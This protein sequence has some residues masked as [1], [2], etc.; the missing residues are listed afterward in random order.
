M[1]ATTSTAKTCHGQTWEKSSKE[2]VIEHKESL[3]K[4]ATEY[5]LTC[6][7]TSVEININFGV[8]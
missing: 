4:L 6:A 2:L 5:G 8:V 1:L 7:L 3:L